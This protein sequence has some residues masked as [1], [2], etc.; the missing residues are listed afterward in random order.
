V[1]IS[2]LPACRTECDPHPLPAEPDELDRLLHAI[3]GKCTFGLS[4]ASMGLAFLDWAVHFAKAPH[5][6][7]DITR[8]WAEEACRLAEAVA[9]GEEPV[10]LPNPRD[11]RFDAPGWHCFPFDLIHQ[12]FLLAEHWW[13]EATTNV[14]GTAPAN[15]RIVSF[16]ARQLMDMVSPSNLPWLNP[17]VIEKT[18][19]SA[20]ANLVQG[21]QNFSTDLLVALGGTAKQDFVPG[22]DVAVTPGKVVLRNELI[23]LIQ[24]APAGDQVRPEPVLIIPA[25]IMKYYILDLSPQNSLIRHLVQAGYTVY[26]ISWRNP[27]PELSD[28]GFDDYRRL[29]V[30]AAL[31]AIGGNKIHACGYCLGGTL[32]AVT[33]AAMA[34][35]GDD[36]LCSVTL[37]AAQTDFKEAGELQLFITEGQLAYLE[38]LMWAQGTLNSSQMAG[39]FQLL[40]S[41][42]LIWSR[43]VRTYLLG[44]HEHPNDLRSWNQDATRMPY[45]MHA[46][47]LRRLFLD[48]DLAEGRFPVEGRPVSVEDIHL[49]IFA[50]G[51]ETD[52]VAP[53]H[54]VH[55]IHLLNPGDITFVLAS[56]G[57]NTG[58]VSEPGHHDRCYSI[59][60]R[61]AGERYIG[62]G[63]WHSLAE[64]HAGSW[65]PAWF[66]WL[67][68]HSGPLRKPPAMAKALGDAPGRYVNQH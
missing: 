2:T 68:A 3:E 62:P 54:S 33:A 15:E 63:E 31:D 14:R 27:G 17:E 26:C 9:A 24:Y 21:A 65:W 64:P 50:V 38:D 20:G 58:I 51:T 34:R 39:A 35:D 66:A 43:V 7:L 5:R 13:A 61:A 29:G 44:E 1:K 53:W 56:G 41:N 52:H 48:N 16:T 30:M 67:D 36:R 55:K 59:R 28:T 25:W 46:E 32:L 22:R 8:H 47:Y 6:R 37:L 4:P 45:R 60:T 23:E 11:H 12:S 57:H 18:A 40:R 10:V 49:P 19:E 42:D